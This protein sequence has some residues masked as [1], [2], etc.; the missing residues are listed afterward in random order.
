VRPSLFLFV[1]QLALVVIYGRFGTAYGSYLQ[2]QAVLVLA[3]GTDRLS[4]NVGKYLLTY[5]A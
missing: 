2:G 4:R 3:D 5:A 1:T